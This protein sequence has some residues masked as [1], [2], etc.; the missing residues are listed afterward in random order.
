MT[1]IPEGWKLVRREVYDALAA[2]LGHAAC[3]YFGTAPAA[4]GGADPLKAALE[5]AADMIESEYC[6]HR[7]PHGAGVKHCYSAFIYEALAA[8]PAAPEMVTFNNPTAPLSPLFSPA[9]AAPEGATRWC[10]DCQEMVGASHHIAP[11][12]HTPAPPQKDLM[13]SSGTAVDRDAGSQC[14]TAVAEREC[15]V[16]GGRAMAC[17]VLGHRPPGDRTEWKRKPA[18]G[19]LREALHY[20][21]FATPALS[22]TRR[23]EIHAAALKELNTPVAC[24]LAA[25]AEAH[26][27]LEARATTGSTILIPEGEAPA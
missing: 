6:S 12:A 24:P 5:K 19:A 4:P 1:T 21:Q 3:L 15:P 2:G 16:C 22:L 25:A 9:P 14:P 26:R 17:A 10:P 8:A 7:W 18:A 20:F 13:G 23:A 11:P 27:A